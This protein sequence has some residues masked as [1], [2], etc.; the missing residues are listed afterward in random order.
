MPL[1]SVEKM[2]IEEI[3]Q[4][5]RDRIDLIESGKSLIKLDDIGNGKKTPKLILHLVP[6]KAF[7]PSMIFGLSGLY[8]DPNGLKPVYSSVATSL[9]NSE[10]F[11]VCGYSLLRLRGTV[12]SYVQIFHNGIIEAVD[13]RFLNEGYILGEP[14]KKHLIISLPKYLKT[15]EQIGVEPPIFF[16][17]SMLNFKDFNT[18]FDVPLNRHIIEQDC[19]L[20]PEL[21]ISEI[22]NIESDIQ[23][24]I[25]PV[26]DIVWNA[27]GQ[28]DSDFK[29]ES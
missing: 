15:Q 13:L 5:R 11:A 17:L 29:D 6:E 16:M 18:D 20:L 14:F 22:E 9:Y 21:K 23:T 10:G 8:R 1:N 26:F 4:F 12:G 19:L 27:A 3:R 7:D 24:K 2:T 28:P 25:K